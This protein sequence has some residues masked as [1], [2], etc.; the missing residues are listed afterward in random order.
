M[1]TISQPAGIILTENLALPIS[2][3]REIR[4]KVKS[5]LPINLFIVNKHDSIFKCYQQLI[6]NT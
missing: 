2:L 4:K 3:P 1:K 6:Q 5:W